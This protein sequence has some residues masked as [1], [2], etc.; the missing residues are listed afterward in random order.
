MTS[1]APGSLGVTGLPVFSPE[2]FQLRDFGEPEGR[3]ENFS[4]FSLPFYS[5]FLSVSPF[6]LKKGNGETK[7]FPEGR[8]KGREEERK[9]GGGEKGREEEGGEK[10]REEERM[11]GKGGKRREREGRADK[12]REKE[13]KGRE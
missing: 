8:G 4:L 6:V 2:S 5:L 10:G 12:E 1:A 3:K 9:E 13:R 7:D 11:G